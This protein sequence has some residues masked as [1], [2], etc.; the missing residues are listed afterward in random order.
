MVA[1]KFALGPI[2]TERA[3]APRVA[4]SFFL[5]IAVKIDAYDSTQEK[6]DM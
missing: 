4:T 1:E 2:P 3:V 6:D 5:V